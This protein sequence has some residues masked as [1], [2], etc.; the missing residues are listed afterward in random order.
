M[1]DLATAVVELTETGG[2]TCRVMRVKFQ[3]TAKGA[4]LT[5]Q[6][7]RAM[8]DL[9]ND[10]VRLHKRIRRAHASGRRR[11]LSTS[12]FSNTKLAT[13]VCPPPAFSKP[14][15]SFSAILKTTSARIGINGAEGA[16][17]LARTRS[18][19]RPSP[20]AVIWSSGRTQLDAGRR[21][22]RCPIVIPLS[23]NRV[24]SSK[25]KQFDEVAGHLYDPRPFPKRSP[26]AQAGESGG[27]RPRPALAWAILT[28]TG[29]SLMAQRARLVSEKIRGRKSW[30]I[31]RRRC[32]AK[33]GLETL[34][35]NQRRMAR[36]KAK[37]ARRIRDI[38]HK[39][40][41]GGCASRQAASLNGV[42]QPT[43]IAEAPD[44]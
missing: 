27:R 39:I 38:N 15:A 29:E 28:E 26:V 35:Q 17:P 36:L 44:A 32:L 40:T 10:M 22:W 21:E 1:A 43:G 18:G 13:P 14:S 9:W 2:E 4:A 24:L 12:I 42:D 20:I 6:A 31:C 23:E 37:S 25:P 11:A 33:T 16:L 41:A 34:S 5:D 3:R 30:A 19:L 8:A 7:R